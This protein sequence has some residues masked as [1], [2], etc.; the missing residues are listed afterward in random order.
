[1]GL[2]SMRS[3]ANRRRWI[4]LYAFLPRQGPSVKSQL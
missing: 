4:T 3:T 2:A 1:M